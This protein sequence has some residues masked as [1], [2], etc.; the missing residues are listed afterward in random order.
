MPPR[1]L[2]TSI[3]L[4]SRFLEVVNSAPKQDLKV[5]FT[6]PKEVPGPS[7]STDRILDR[8]WRGKH[9]PYPSLPPRLSPAI[10][11]GD[12]LPGMSGGVFDCGLDRDRS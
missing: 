1:A 5:R 12:N 10:F 3:E 7:F 8:P 9:D 6:R 4:R 2:S 11:I